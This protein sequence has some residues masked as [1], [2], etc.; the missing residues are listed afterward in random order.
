M[1]TV[2]TQLILAISEEGRRARATRL[3]FTGLSRVLGTS[4]VAMFLNIGFSAFLVFLFLKRH[5]LGRL[6]RLG[7]YAGVVLWILHFVLENSTVA[8][9][10][11][12]LVF[13]SCLRLIV[14]HFPFRAG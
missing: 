9:I 12:P 2:L 5:E 10:A 6:G 1:Q 3:R 4:K 14:E 11:V 8:Y 7:Y 13:L